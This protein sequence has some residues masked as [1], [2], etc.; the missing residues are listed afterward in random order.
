MSEEVWSEEVPAASDL[1]IKELNAACEKYALLRERKKQAEDIVD[2]IQAEVKELEVKILAYLKEYAMPNFKGSFGTISIKT[3]KSI[4]QPE[5]MQ[6]K[7]EF[8]E[9]LKA[10][11]VFE[12]MVAVNS[13]T[14]SS[15]A[16]KEIEAKEKEGVFGWTPP[17][18]KPASEFQSLSLRKA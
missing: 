15:W 16:S 12:S 14:L 5:D 8:F 13:K 9:Y 7:L 17:G 18:L 4:S 11:G 1:T 6:A 10:Q 3:S 2:G